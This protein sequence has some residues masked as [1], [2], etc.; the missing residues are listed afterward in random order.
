MEVLGSDH[1]YYIGIGGEGHFGSG[2]TEELNEL[3]E[4]LL[5]KTIDA[6]KKADPKAI[7]LTGQPFPYAATYQAQKEAIKKSD[8]I[9]VTCFL[10]I[11]QRL[12]DFKLNDYYW[13]LRWIRDGGSVR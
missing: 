3:T 7:I 9:V 13:G 10:A 6:V 12:P 2:S 1:Y 4:A 5:F 11:P 8:A